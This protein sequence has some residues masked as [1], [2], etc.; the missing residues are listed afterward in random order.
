MAR[1]RELRFTSER[2]KFRTPFRIS[3]RTFTSADL[4]LVSISQGGRTGRG[5]GAGVY[6]LDETGASMMADVASVSD[7]IE[8]GADR[9]QL[10]SLLP[11]GGARNALDCALWDLEA[12]QKNTTIWQLTGIEPR[13]TRTVL[14]IGIGTPGGDG[15]GRDSPDA[16]RLKVKLD[17]AMPLNASQRCAP[18]GLTTNHRRRQPAGPSRSSP[19]WHHG[20]A[21]SASR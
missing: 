17:A 3:G 2:W 5:E 4:M 11:N 20:L 19:R 18:S 7:A 21:D 9:H 12:K 10:Q 16:D 6:Y 8:S 14:T 13:P 1:V 15:R